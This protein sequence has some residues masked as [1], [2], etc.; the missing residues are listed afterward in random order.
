MTGGRRGGKM[1]DRE[2]GRDRLRENRLRIPRQ[3]SEEKKEAGHAWRAEIKSPKVVARLPLT[4][5]PH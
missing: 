3:L 1:R 4:C 5:P 2:K